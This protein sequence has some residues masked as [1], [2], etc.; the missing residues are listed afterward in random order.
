VVQLFCDPQSPSCLD[1]TLPL[2]EAVT[3]PDGAVSLSLPD[4]GSP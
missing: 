4:P 2:A 1:P 3:G